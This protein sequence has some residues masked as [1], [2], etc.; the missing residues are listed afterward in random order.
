[1]YAAVLEVVLKSVVR[2]AREILWQRN[3]SALLVLNLWVLVF[4][5]AT[6]HLKSSV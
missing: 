1:V 4:W 6:H 2:G 3:S 5:I